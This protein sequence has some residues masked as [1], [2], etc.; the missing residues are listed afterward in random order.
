M[1]ISDLKQV[2]KAAKIIANIYTLKFL[3]NSA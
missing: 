2:S 3:Y 1:N